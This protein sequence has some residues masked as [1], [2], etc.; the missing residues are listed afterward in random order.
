MNYNNM[1]YNNKYNKS[2]INNIENKNNDKN[3]NKN[4]DKNNTRVKKKLYKVYENYIKD[5][6]PNPSPYKIQNK[7]FIPFRQHMDL[8]SNT[9][10]SN[11]IYKNAPSLEGMLLDQEYHTQNY[12]FIKNIH[13]KAKEDFDLLAKNNE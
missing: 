7:H 1:N 11:N 2:S 6:K 10:L 8:S 13:T 4:N 12:K 9:Y 5:K 3:N